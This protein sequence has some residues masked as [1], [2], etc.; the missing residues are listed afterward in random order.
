MSPLWILLL[1]MVIV[2]GGV[3]V[4]RI[5]AFLALILGALVVALLTPRSRS[6][7]GRPTAF[8]WGRSLR[9]CAWIRQT[10]RINRSPCFR[11]K[12]QMEI[13]PSPG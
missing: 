1:G 12:G 3:L 6:A 11:S 10:K 2:V 5:H 7:P 4:L 9:C 13:R 8:W